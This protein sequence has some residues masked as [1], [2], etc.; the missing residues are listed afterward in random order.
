MFLRNF[1][2]WFRITTR[3]TYAPSSSSSWMNGLA[4]S[5]KDIGGIQYGYFF[6]WSVP[7]NWSPNSSYYPKYMEATLRPLNPTSIRLGSGSS[8]PLPTD[9]DVDSPISSLANVTFSVVVGQSQTTGGVTMTVS[10]SATNTGSE[11]VTIRQLGI[12][13]NFVLRDVS[14][15]NI[16]DFSNNSTTY[17]RQVM[18]AKHLLAEPIEIQ[19]G[20]T[21]GFTVMV[22]MS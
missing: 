2:E 9:Y 5:M 15:C 18:I 12:C 22:E 8:A 10:C 16:S 20:D 3:T 17:F 6:G 19:P 1:W 14:G 4:T 13:H 21:K 11:P 7:Y